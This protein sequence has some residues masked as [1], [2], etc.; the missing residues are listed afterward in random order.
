MSRRCQ[1]RHNR[2]DASIHRAVGVLDKVRQRGGDHTSEEGKARAKPPSGGIA[3]SAAQ[4]GLALAH[5]TFHCVR[6]GWHETRPSRATPSGVLCPRGHGW[7]YARPATSDE[8]PA[9]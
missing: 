9:S 7:A 5:A 6:C 2:D 3:S 1:D 4:T 8:E